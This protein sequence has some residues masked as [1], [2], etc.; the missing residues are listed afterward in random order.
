MDGSGKVQAVHAAWHLDVR[1]KQRNVGAV[2]QYRKRFVGIR[3]FDGAKTGVGN[4]FR[5]A[6]AE[7]LVVF[8]HQDR[9]LHKGP[10]Q[11]HNY[12]MP[13]RMSDY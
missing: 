4:D 8:D 5:Y 2:F 6:H 3:R 7:H 13:S 12:Q 11:G 1:E 9:G 10:G